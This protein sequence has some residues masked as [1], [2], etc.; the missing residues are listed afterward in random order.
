MPPVYGT[1]VEATA[2]QSK[3]G[4]D[5]INVFHFNFDDAAGAL[6]SGQADT[7]I[8]WIDTFYTN[9][10]AWYP[11]AW[12]LDKISVRD[13]NASTGPTYETT[14][15]PLVTGTNANQQMPPNLAVCVSKKTG[16]GGRAYRGRM[17]LGPFTEADNTLDGRVN[18]TLRDDI[19]DECETLIAS[20]AATFEWSVVSTV[21]NG[22]DRA[23]ALV[24]PITAVS[25]NDEWDHQDRRKN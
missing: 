4:I 8:A 12:T 1:Y 6:T 11:T 25:C 19:V 24:T 7:I 18:V 16:I 17:Y 3:G 22:A 21:L 5:I 20:S 10:L 2:E 9:L 14:V 15:T 13:W 23:A